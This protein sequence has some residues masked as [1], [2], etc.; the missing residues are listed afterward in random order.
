MNKI[1]FFTLT[2]ALVV[3]TTLW[4]RGLEHDTQEI[5]AENA[6]TVAISGDFAVGEF[7]VT[8]EDISAVAVFDIHY[9]PRE[10]DYDIDYEVEGGTGFLD[11]DSYSRRNHDLDTEDSQWE[12]VL[13]NRY[14]VTL[15]LDIG[16]CEAEFDLGGIPLTELSLEIGAASVE[17]IFSEPNPERLEE[18]SIEAGASSVEMESIGNANFDEFS[19]EGGVGSFDLDFRGEYSGES[20]ISIELGM[21]SADIILPRGVPV[22]VET[23]GDNW[24]SSIDFHND[25]LEEIDDDLYETEDFDRA[26]NRIILELDLG[27]GSI[28]VYWK[29]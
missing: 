15:D 13:S 25:D 21:G 9:D 8:G 3:C 10:M 29:K 7:L 28:D 26:K 1:L 27:M 23:S 22:R 12:I 24:L 19:F 14:P 11:I 16:A 2:L 6:K 20:E 4:A 18:I 5:D 17:I